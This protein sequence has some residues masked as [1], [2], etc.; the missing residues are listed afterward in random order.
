EWFYEARLQVEIADELLNR[1]YKTFTEYPNAHNSTDACDLVV[2]R[3]ESLEH[4]THW[5]EIKPLWKKSNY[6]NPSKF[7]TGAP[8]KRDVEKL[9][10]RNCDNRWYAVIVFSDDPDL[11]TA[12][13]PLL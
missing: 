5:V 12:C 7:V 1:G 8:F 4:V 6:W 13:D 3:W 2:T 9:A 11:P 10:N